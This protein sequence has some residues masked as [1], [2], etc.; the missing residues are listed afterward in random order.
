MPSEGSVSR[1]L[2]GVQEGDSAAV[3]KLWG[4][5]F[6]RLVSLARLKIRGSPRRAADEEDVALSAFDSFCRNAEQGRFP[7][8]LDRDELWRLL[9]VVTARKASHLVRDESR[10]KRGGGLKPADDRAV[11]EQVLSREPSPQLAAE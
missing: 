10:Q 8:L 11:L 2:T 5:Y 1:W 7:N 3:Q 6:P 9:A 4:R